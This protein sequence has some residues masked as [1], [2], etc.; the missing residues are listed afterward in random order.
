MLEL[1]AIPTLLTVG[2]L[3]DYLSSED[4]DDDFSDDPIQITLEDDVVEFHGTEAKEHVRA[5][6]LDNILTGSDNN[7]LIGGLEGEDTISGEAGDDRLFGGDGSDSASGGVGDDKIFLADGDD[8]VL[9]DPATQSD[10]GNDFIRGGA[11]H[12]VIMDSVGS[13][14]VHGDI[15]HDLLF[16][17][18]GLGLDGTIDPSETNSPDSIHAGFGNDTLVGD[19]GDTL[20]GGAGEDRFVI[21][22]PSDTPGAPAV[23]TDFDLRDDLLSVVFV[24]Q[25]PADP[26]I[27][28]EHDAE[29]DLLRAL[30]D[31]QEVA[32][33]S[34]LGPSDVPFLRTF[35]TTMPEL[36]AGTAA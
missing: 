18:D 21:A 28:F 23:V 12:D 11:G 27:R 24:D 10:A 7:D 19:A 36:L 20:T 29:A 35:V 33:L 1:I 17:V 13:N 9:P 8:F 14:T 5:N 26:T 32:T 4:D 3:W 2:F 6:A 30:V 15:G 16:S 25:S 34:G 22:T 31:G